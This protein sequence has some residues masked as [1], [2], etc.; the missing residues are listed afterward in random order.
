MALITT[1]CQPRII[2]VSSSCDGSLSKANI[3]G[4]TPAEIE[5]LKDL[6][7][8]EAAF[9]YRQMTLG[10]MAGVRE[11]P[12]LDLL[13]SRVKG[14]KGER[15]KSSLG[16]NKSFFLPYFMRAQ[17]D[18]I[19][20][21]AFNIS[22]GEAAPAA[23]LAIHAGAWRVYVTN[24]GWNVGTPNTPQP[25]YVT[26][27]TRLDR[28]FLKEEGVVILNSASGQTAPDGTGRTVMMKVIESEDRTAFAE[29]GLGVGDVKARITLVPYYTSAGWAGVDALTLEANQPE[30]GVVMSGTNSVSDYESW[31]HNQP[32]DMSRRIK[33][34]WPQT[35][36]FTRCHDDLYDEFLKRIFSGDVNPYIEK[37]KELPMSEQN[38][39]QQATYQRKWR[40]TMF[41]GV[42][43]DENQTEEGYRNLPHINDPRTG[44]FIEYKANCKGLHTQIAECGRR[45]DYAGGRLD[46]NALEEMLYQL[47]RHR[48]ID[49]GTIEEIDMMVDRGTANRI[50]GLMSRYYQAKYGT[51]AHSHFGPSD[52]IKFEDR[53]LW[54]RQSYDFDEAHVR[55]NLIV[56]NS[57]SDHKLHFTTGPASAQTQA[58]RGNNA[59][60]IDWSDVEIGVDEVS[61]RK[62]QT[63]DLDTDPDFKCIIKA[64]ITRYEMESVKATPVVGDE[65]R[66]LI[67]ENFSD[68]CPD[69]TVT[70]CPVQ[71]A[72]P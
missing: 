20:S 24:S 72:A 37:F 66:H 18:V 27:L 15:G 54:H 70:A 6:G 43:I 32:S 52:P 2:D 16:P 7:Y 50:K 64:N 68:D 19:N 31:C 47:K 61:M 23:V 56:E 4:L 14:V 46:F 69:Y 65:T 12:L 67:L 57:M 41:Y 9:L 36:R 51:S 60:L 58:T 44:H 22:A 39:K 8:M 10:R 5:K 11:D 49:G 48:E 45:I 29:G 28:Y 33:S 26:N 59:W 53:V 71:T 17:E 55:L 13:I 1:Q 62:S 63:P 21:S 42:P 35:S 38:R 25:A 30:G 3:K 34:Y 40:N